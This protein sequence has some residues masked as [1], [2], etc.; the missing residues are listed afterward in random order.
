LQKLV[1]TTVLKAFLNAFHAGFKTGI[2]Y[3]LLAHSILDNKIEGFSFS[4]GLG[5]GLGINVHEAP[6]ALNQTETGHVEIKNGMCFSIEPGL[7]NP[8]Y[9]G[10]RLEN[11]CYKK[12][13]KIHSFVKTGY[14]GKLI[15]FSRLNEQE[16]EWL[17]G[18][19]IL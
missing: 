15:D 9:F 7:Y 8:E 2:E 6:P 16:K 14:E 12:D 4:H 13:G 5:H 19:E 3:D 10:I 1:Y 11:S 17:K 18:F